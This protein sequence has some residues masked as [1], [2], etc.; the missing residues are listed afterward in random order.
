MALCVTGS[1]VRPTSPIHDYLAALHAR[2]AANTA[3]AVADYIPELAKVDPDA[4]G[5]AIATRD[6]EVYAVGDADLPFTIQSIS[7]P[8]TYGLAL[9]DRGD[10]SVLER[11]GVEPSGEAFNAISL[12]P[13][14]GV[15]RNP[16]INAGAIATCALVCDGPAH[17]AFE[18]ILA[19]YSR[20]AGRGLDVDEA[21]YASESATGDRNRAIGWLLRSASIIQGDP[22]PTLETYFRQCSVRITC[23]DLA[24]IGATLANGGTNPVTGERAVRASYVDE[25]LA[26]MAT[27]GMYDASGEW[28]YRTG[29]PAKSGVGGGVLAVQPGRLG[30]AVFSPRL[31]AQGNS[32]RGIEA[33]RALAQDL[34]LHLFAAARQPAPVLRSATTRRFVSSKRLRAASLAEL[35]EA[36]GDRM[37]VYHL[38]G[39]LGFA[40]VET[41]IREI[42]ATSDA[43]DVFIVNL[44]VVQSLDPAAARMLA[45]LQRQL[46]QI[47]KVLHISEAGRWQP[48]LV[49]AG[50]DPARFHV[51]DELALEVGEE[52]LIGDSGTPPEPARTL[53]LGACALFAGINGAELA[54]LDM[55]LDRREHAAGEVVIESGAPSTELFV[56][57]RGSVAVTLPVGG[58]PRRLGAFGPGMTFGEV[59]FLDREPRSAE[60]TALE[61][62]ECRVLSRETFDNLDAMAPALKARLHV[63]LSL[64]L[65]A[66]LRQANRELASLR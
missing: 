21:V 31:D 12:D 59:G 61:D 20:Y 28:L 57:L 19:T 52:H 58:T 36:R 45:A 39:A 41:V 30:I 62:V 44:R 56:I 54:T 38:Q 48:V 64:G 17:T 53:E 35:L 9:E 1:P 13:K 23:R 16:L 60:V 46:A 6:G 27:C 14:T 65:A 51:A 7:K 15:P 32:V 25:I 40:S 3:G 11:V 22:A 2:L 34:G 47:G 55:L 5:I 43:T 26:V 49:A 4:F 42:V 37:R 24:M 18:R 10:T 50:C 29:L 33:C 8:L 66:V 63:N